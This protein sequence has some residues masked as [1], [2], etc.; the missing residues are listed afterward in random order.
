M[1]GIAG[2]YG[3]TPL[4]EGDGERLAH[5][6]QRPLLRRGPDSGRTHHDSDVLLV[7]RRLSIIDLSPAATQPLWN[8]TGTACVI[9]NGEIY[10]FAVLRKQLEAKGHRFRSGSDSEVLI[11]LYEE[12]GI[13]HC[14]REAKGMFAFALWDVT[15][16]SLFL[17]RDRLGIKPL[18]LAE[19]DQGVTFGS[20]L[21][22]VLADSAVPREFRPDALVALFKWGFIPTPWSSVRAVRHVRPGTFVRVSGGRVIDEQRWWVDAPEEGDATDE[23]L[24]GALTN[25]VSSHL[26]ADVPVGALLSAGI[27]SG[28]IVALA[29][30]EERHDLEAWT[31]SHRG[32]REDECD[33]AAKMAAHVGV[34][35]YE[36]PVGGEGLTEDG[37]DAVVAAMDEPLGVSSLVGLHE[38]YRS[39]APHRRVVL[40]G[41]GGDE[42]FGGYDWHAGMPHIPSW[43]RSALFR[44]VAPGLSG[45]AARGGRLGSVGR[46]A[47][48]AKLHPA[49]RHLSRIRVASD[50]MLEALGVPLICE[51]PIEEAAIDAWDRFQVSGDLECMLAVD[52]ATSLVDEMLAKVDVASMAYS[53]EAR[54]PLLADDVVAVSKRIPATRKRDGQTGK[55]CLRQ[56]MAELAPLSIAQREKTGFNSPVDAWLRSSAGPVLR[57]RSRAGL[58]ALDAAPL[59]LSPKLT[60]VS[61]VLGTWIEAVGPM[62]A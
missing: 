37:F 45:F 36:V 61:A 17:A 58:A 44:S 15:T 22:A 8:E 25:A 55:L 33:L 12:G 52:R 5:A 30:R 49:L 24:R 40:S 34:R 26:V 16:R 2:R 19:H 1:C 48:A 38:L 51:D 4:S 20:T 46:V 10:N 62:S 3:R 13:A 41:D 6:L 60:F 53:V 50:E 18:A 11:H 42:L 39:I 57:E 28:L 21:P 23:E 35:H 43:G 32:H 54:V 31:V 47:A 59:D 9:V 14:C 56:W 29:A 7:H 27:D